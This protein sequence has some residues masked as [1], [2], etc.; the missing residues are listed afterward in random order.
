MDQIMIDVGHIKDVSVGDEAVLLG[1]QGSQQISAEELAQ[2]S[3]TIPYEIVCSIAP[4][5]PRVYIDVT[6]HFR[7]G[8]EIPHAEVCGVKKP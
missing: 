7:V 3:G 2:L 4:R 5:V 1:S 8:N 6:P